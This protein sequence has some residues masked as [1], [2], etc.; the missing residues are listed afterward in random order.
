MSRIGT[1][2]CKHCH[3]EET[4][5]VDWAMGSIERECGGCGEEQTF[6]LQGDFMTEEEANVW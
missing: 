5:E 6:V 3:H 2:R 4:L 1:Y